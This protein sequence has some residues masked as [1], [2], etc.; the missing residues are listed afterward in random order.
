VNQSSWDAA[1]AHEVG[2]GVYRIPLPMPDDGL[3]AVNVYAICDGPRVV[4]VDSG[5]A[6]E[7][8]R[9]Q[10]EA[11]LGELGYA[12]A[13]V[14]ECLVTH[15]HPDHYTGAVALRR[16]L[17][18]PI[19]LGRGEGESLTAFQDTA[20]EDTRRAAELARAGAKSLLDEMGEL[21][22]APDPDSYGVPDRWLDDGDELPLAT[23]TLRVVATPGHTRGHVVFYDD[24]AGALFAGDHVLPHITPSIGLESYSNN[25]PLRDYLASLRLVRARP[26]ARLL[27]AHGPVTE[28]AHARVDELLAHHADRLDA[29]RAAVRD[30]ADTAFTVA[31]ALRWTRRE[32]RFAE[33]DLFNRALA[34][35]ESQAHLDVLADQGRL[36]VTE[37]PGQAARYSM[38]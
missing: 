28:S 20:A 3:R 15:M 1:G 35:G 33:L 21:N 23:R 38:P 34:I 25:L 37:A 13:D 2:P 29:T 32:R 36:A 19:A 27:P 12:L 26:D 4:L 24:S 18:T 6:L 7:A 17:G 22:W 16:A 8:S 30:G 14:S 9:A 10:L 31:Q 5:L 11:S